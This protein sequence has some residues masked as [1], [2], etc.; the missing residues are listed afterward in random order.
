MKPKTHTE[1]TRVLILGGIL[2]DGEQ[3]QE[4]RI[5]LEAK[6]NPTTRAEIMRWF[7]GIV[8]FSKTDNPRIETIT[9]T[10]RETRTVKEISK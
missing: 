3:S 7:P 5:A 1:T 8:G 9:R 4:M 2:R 10:V 6:D